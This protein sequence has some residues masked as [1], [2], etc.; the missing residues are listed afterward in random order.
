MPDVFVVYIDA[1]ESVEVPERVAKLRRQHWIFCCQVVN[2]ISDGR[3]LTLNVAAARDARKRRRQIDFDGHCRGILGMSKCRQWIHIGR[4]PCWNNRSEY[5]D[6][7][8]HAV[9]N[10]DQSPVGSG[11]TEDHGRTKTCRH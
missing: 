9:G 6:D 10:R 11:N 2:R 4:T 5:G 1:H 7:A 3:A 8:Q